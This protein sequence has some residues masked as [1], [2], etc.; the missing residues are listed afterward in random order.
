MCSVCEEYQP[1]VCGRQQTAG[2]ASILQLSEIWDC[3]PEKCCCSPRRRRFYPRASS[4]HLA[5]L[6]S[7]VDLL[8][9]GY[10]R[11]HL[12]L[13]H[14]LEEAGI[15]GQEEL[16]GS[17][18]QTANIT[19]ARLF[20]VFLR[21]FGSTLLLLRLSLRYFYRDKHH[22]C[23]QQAG[24]SVGPQTWQ[25]T[26]PHRDREETQKNLDHVNYKL[27]KALPLLSHQIVSSC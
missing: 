6:V 23:D 18:S 10:T 24:S 9:Y 1:R 16:M 22:M 25:Q 13:R 17:T 14:K 27:C 5:H 8:K 12:T 11:L 20:G 19:F 21:L 2:T 26:A 4:P 3:T 7:K 15:R